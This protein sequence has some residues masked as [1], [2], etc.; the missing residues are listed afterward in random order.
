QLQS[1]TAGGAFSLLVHDRNDAPELLDVH[2]F[3]NDWEKSTSLDLRHGRPE[4]IDTYTAH[5][6]INGGNTEAM[7]DAAYT[8]W[9]TDALAGVSTVLIADSNE[10]VHALNQRA[11]ADLIL[12]GTVNARREVAL[13]GD[14]RAG[15]GDTIITRKND[16]RLRTPRGWVRNGDRWIVTDIRNDGSL[17]A[18]RADSRGT[19]ILPADYVSDHVDLG[20][21]VTAFRAQGITTDTS[22]VLVDPSTTREN[23]YVAMT[24]GRHANLVYVATDRPDDNH[25]T[26]H[27]ADDPDATARSVLYRVLQ[28][29]GAE[30]SAHETITAEHET[31]GSVGQLAAEYE[32]IAQA[33]QHDRFATLIRNS[34]L[35]PEE[36]EDTI[37][38]DAFGALT[39][40]LRQAEAN[41]HN[42]DALMPRM[43]AARGFGDADDIASVLHH[44]LARAT[45]RPA[46]SGR[47][48]KAPRL[49]AGLI[50]EATGP[51]SAEMRKALKERRELIQQRAE[52]VLDQALAERQEWVL[53]LGDTPAE[54]R[55]AAAWKRRARTVAAYRDRYGITTRNPLGPAPDTDAQKIDAA[56]AKA[57]L[58][59][60]RDLAGVEGNDDLSRTVR[61]E[62]ASRAL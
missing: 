26:P 59:R 1:V 5:G 2:R 27:P 57:A 31:W 55:A 47:T 41:H 9:R 60:L 61:R 36:A 39:A 49:I 13:E 51:M 17:T 33:A 16:R 7:I 32:T 14:A 38:S 3:V 11:R 15:V 21:A 62:V 50:P 6:R 54:P 53:A 40:E 43:V 19:V 28:H 10:S 52:A 48:R 56:R 22:H 44:R 24:R 8:A 29:V 45:D 34:G 58:A 20:Y 18:R 46:G 35:T 42:I 4:A 37:H 23:L 30:L 12:D 25:T